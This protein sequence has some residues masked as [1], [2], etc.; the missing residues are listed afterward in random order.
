VPNAKSWILSAESNKPQGIVNKINLTTITS[1]VFTRA[2]IV[3]VARF[4]ERTW[5]VASTIKSNPA[6]FRLAVQVIIVKLETPT[7]AGEFPG[8]IS[9]AIGVLLALSQAVRSK[10]LQKPPSSIFAVGLISSIIF[11]ANLPVGR[12]NADLG[13]VLI[14]NV[15][16]NS[17]GT[18]VTMLP[19]GRR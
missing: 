13:P 11:K 4:A 10:V 14:S 16:E 7:K 12:K 18:H 9:E 8:P 15:P 19:F 3:I 17:P 1:K 6:V 2:L 5:P